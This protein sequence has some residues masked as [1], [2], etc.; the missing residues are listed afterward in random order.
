M[1]LRATLIVLSLLF[2]SAVASARPDKHDEKHRATKV[3]RT[4]AVD[5]Q[6]SIAVCIA[7]GSITVNGWD[8]NE[9]RARSLEAADVVFKRKDEGSEPVKKVDVRVRDKQSEVDHNDPCEA[10]SELELD[11]PRAATVQ[12]QTRDSDI[13]VADVAIVYANTQNGDVDIERAAKIVDAGTIGG[14]ISLRESRGRISVHSASGNI[15]A[16][17]V[18]PAESVDTFEARSLGGE[19]TLENVRHA[20]LSAHTLNGDLSVTGP[21]TSGGRYNFRTMSGDITLTLP[22]DSSFQFVARLSYSAD[23]ITDFPVTLISQSSGKMA[24]LPAP[25]PAPTTAP[26][27]APPDA[28]KPPAPE[29]DGVVVKVEPEVITKIKTK[30]GQPSVVVDLSSLSLR[31]L[32]G[33]RGTGDAKL[34]LASFSGTIHLQK[35]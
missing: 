33:F 25:M 1:K 2:S 17:D 11:V 6:V 7:S 30:G 9:I 24:P 27:A 14:G 21:L 32:E 18:R 31:R 10:Y 22:E 5:A 26:T 16:N 35:Q 13:T 23:I 19:I 15:D 4:L 8:R 20:Q 3:E 29:S 12:L 34:E 28:A